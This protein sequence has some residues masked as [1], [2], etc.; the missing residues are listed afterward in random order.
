MPEAKKAKT[1][2]P[3][4]AK[5]EP[6]FQDRQYDGPSPVPREDEAERLQYL[7]DFDGDFGEGAVDSDEMVNGEALCFF[8]PCPSFLAGNFR[9]R[10]GCK[11]EA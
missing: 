6:Q 1:S 10:E 5:R 4:A 3:K 7:F 11:D 2:K 9:R 8:V